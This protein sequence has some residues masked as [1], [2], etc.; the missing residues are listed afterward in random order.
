MFVAS[1]GWVDIQYQSLQSLDILGV[2]L[3]LSPMNKI[4]KT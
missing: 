2:S 3:E 4:P 1:T